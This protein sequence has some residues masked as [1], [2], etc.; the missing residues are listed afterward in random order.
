MIA[1]RGGIPDRVPC[2]PKT[3]RWVRY[4][5]KCPCPRHHLA[6]AEQFGFDAILFCGSYISRS[7]GNDYV[8]SP[9][10]GYSYSPNGLYGDLPEVNVDLRIENTP[11]HV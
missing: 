9:G 11:E 10:G 8:Y 5:Y 4:H 1:L 2:W 7:A 3:T 6:G